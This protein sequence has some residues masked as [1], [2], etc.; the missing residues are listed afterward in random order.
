[1]TADSISITAVAKNIFFFWPIS[2]DFV[3]NRFSCVQLFVILW[4]VA[5]QA[6]HP[7]DS[8]GSNT[9]V[10][11]HASSRGIFLTQGLNLLLLCLLH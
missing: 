9:G 2:N 10:G 4:A 6:P 3:L 8:P 11:C 5:H 7:W 1:M